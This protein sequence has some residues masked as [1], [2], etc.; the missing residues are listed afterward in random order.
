LLIEILEITLDILAR[1]NL[2]A[3]YVILLTH[4]VW[5]CRIVLLTLK[6]EPVLRSS[7]VSGHN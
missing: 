6:C 7:V 5:L 4:C 2:S 3:G 1:V